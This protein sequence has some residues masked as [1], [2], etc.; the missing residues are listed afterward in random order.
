MLIKNFE[1]FA[2]AT[3]SGGL[4]ALDVSKKRIGVALTDHSQ[5]VAL[6]LR[7]IDRGKFHEDATQIT[8]LYAAYNCC[9]LVVGYPIYEGSAHTKEC[10]SVRAFTRK[11]TSEYLK[12]PVWLENEE[13]S[14]LAAQDLAQEAQLHK[15]KKLDDL[16]AA[17][18]LQL[19]LNRKL[20]MNKNPA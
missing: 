3:S 20:T 6:P 19:T 15:N 10:Q 17:Y 14:T 7:V 9:G 11:L 1:E 2:K 12:A 4:M 16:A 8:K 18:F 13:Y 5:K